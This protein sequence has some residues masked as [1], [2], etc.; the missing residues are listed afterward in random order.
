MFSLERISRLGQIKGM[1][2]EP[3]PSDVLCKGVG[4]NNYDPN[5]GRDFDMDYFNDDYA[6]LWGPTG[7]DDLLN[8]RDQNVNLVRIYNWTG[9]ENGG[10][11]M[12]NHIPYLDR[13][14]QLGLGTMV[15]FSNYNATISGT[16]AQNTANSMVN[17]IAG[18]GA[19]HTAAKMWQVTNEFELTDNIR[20]E[21]VARLVEYIVRA[22]ESAGITADANKI[23]IVVGVSTA[24]KYGVPGQS[25]GMI[26]ALRCAFV[27][28]GT[29]PDGTVVRGNPYLNDRNVWTERFVIGIQS[30]QFLDEIENFVKGM[31]AKYESEVPIL[32]TEHGFNSVSAAKSGPPYPGNGGTHDVD[33][34]AKIVARQMANINALCKQYSI[35]RGMCFFQWLNTYYKCGIFENGRAIYSNTCTE[36]NF[37]QIKWNDFGAPQPT[38]KKFGKT[39]KGQPYPIDDA[40]PKSPVFDAVKSGF[41]QSQRQINAV[42]GDPT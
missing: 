24:V 41:A 27:T 31:W 15:A 2:Y 39:R 30:F 33:N 1:A 34:Q 28:G 23:P 21:D 37:G 8:I 26:Q 18:N 6:Q 10:H 11:T 7:R 12:R 20:A 25:M 13:C 14:Q 9:N 32:L 35:L 4:P 40:L 3:T 19:L 29:L 5:Q 36:G 17:E 42:S 16:K 22:E 38:P